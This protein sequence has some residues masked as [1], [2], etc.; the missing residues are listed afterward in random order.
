[1]AT[2]LSF[3]QLGVHHVFGIMV[4]AGFGARVKGPMEKPRPR[5][6]MDVAVWLATLVISKELDQSES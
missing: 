3:G 6:K 5:N 4:F 2:L 1:M